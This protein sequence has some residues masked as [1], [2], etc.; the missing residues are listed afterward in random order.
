MSKDPQLQAELDNLE[1]I[2]ATLAAASGRLVLPE[3]NLAAMS[4]PLREPHPDD[5]PALREHWLYFLQGDDGG[6]IKI[7]RSLKHPLTRAEQCQTGYPFGRL[8]VVAVFRGAAIG[9]RTLHSQ[10]AHLRL[11]GEWFAL[12][13]DLVDHVAKLNRIPWAKIH[14]EVAR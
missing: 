4:V 6:P 14:A 10:F 1:E 7:G 5:P 8:R 9:E 3:A 13:A 11:R 2:R 12:G